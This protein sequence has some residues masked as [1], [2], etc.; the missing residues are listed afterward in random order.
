MIKVLKVYRYKSSGKLIATSLGDGYVIPLNS[1]LSFSSKDPHRIRRDTELE[2]TSYRIEVSV[3]S[4]GSMQFYQP[5]RTWDENHI[6]PKSTDPNAP[7]ERRIDISPSEEFSEVENRY[8]G[9]SS[10]HPIAYILFVCTF[11]LVWMI[12]VWGIWPPILTFVSG[13][14]IIYLTT[15]PGDSIRIK[16]VNEAKERLRKETENKLKEA[17]RDVHFWDA[18]DG[19]GFENAVAKIYK[20]MGFDVEFTPRTNDQGVDLILK[21]DNEDI[22]V[23]CKKYKKN[24]GVGAVREL[25]GV[26]SSWPNASKAVLV[27]LFDFTSAAK[28]FAQEHD[29]ELFSVARNYLN[30]DYRPQ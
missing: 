13:L 1:D 9:Q 29:I 7:L 17:M 15:T 10:G 25:V 26:R 19:I 8:V 24:V 21:K 2:E 5:L 12:G 3:E 14:L 18:L 6:P 30:S 22:I 20:E 23:Q 16:E 28:A 4:K 27:A 11:F